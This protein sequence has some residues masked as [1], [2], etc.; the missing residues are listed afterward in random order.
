MYEKL[1]MERRREQDEE[2]EREKERTKK[3]KHEERE[4]ERER[5][6]LQSTM[7][8]SSE[9]V[10]LI[11]SNCL[12]VITH[13][14][15]IFSSLFPSVSI[16]L[17]LLLL[18]LYS[19]NFFLIL[20]LFAFAKYNLQTLCEWLSVTRTV[21]RNSSS[22]QRHAHLASIYYLGLSLFVC[23]LSCVSPINGFIDAID[24]FVSHT[25]PKA[26]FLLFFPTFNILSM[27]HEYLESS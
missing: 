22:S 25:V 8:R 21:T 4:R 19:H 16:F 20:L 6:S 23:I 9:G 12:P 17:F 18:L 26:T 14:F 5:W 7:C 24:Q 10:L 11:K 2:E 1:E 15:G 3:R 27:T 13:M